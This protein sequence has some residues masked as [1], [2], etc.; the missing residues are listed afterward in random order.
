MEMMT[1]K[2]CG[3]NDFYEFNGKHVCK[4]CETVFYNKERLKTD[5]LYLL[6]RR[7]KEEMNSENAVKYYEMILLDDPLNW[8]PVFYSSF[9]KAYGTTIKDIGNSAYTMSKNFNSVM[10]IVST[11]DVNDTEKQTIVAEIVERTLHLANMLFD[12]EMNYYRDL[13]IYLKSDF[14]SD[15]IDRL[16]G[17]KT[18]LYTLGDSIEEW[19][20]DNEMLMSLAQ[21]A[22]RQ[23]I[24]VHRKY[25]FMLA[26]VDSAQEIIAMYEEKIQS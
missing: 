21:Q 3:S 9:F 10:M 2:N 16:S 11:D 23:G 13:D 12:A 15:H 20:G 14:R 26:D 7:A 18:M 8:E 6:A 1:C 24:A 19:F 5:R 22:W 25:A 4:F 17:V